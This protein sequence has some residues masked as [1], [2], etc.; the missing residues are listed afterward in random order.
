MRI[1]LK[2]L[3]WFPTTAAFLATVFVAP[4]STFAQPTDHLV[5]PSDLTRAAAGASHERQQNIDTLNK[6]LSSPEV[7][8]AIEAAHM[9][10]QEVKG[11]VSGLS[12]QELAQLASRA[13]KAQK[14]FAAGTI[15]NHDL[16]LILVAIAVLILLIV[17][18]H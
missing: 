1:D 14:D 17:A 10:P 15:S 7:Q 6:A 2:K 18:V 4:N 13:N 16:L 3:V 5:S 8:K 11:A 9:N 12:D